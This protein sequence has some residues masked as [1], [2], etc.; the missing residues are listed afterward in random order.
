[1]SDQM[2]YDLSQATEG[3]PN[4]FIRK[5]YLSLL[6]NQNGSYS[7][8]QSV[9]DTSQLSNSNRYMGYQSAY[10]QIPMIMTLTADANSALFN[11]TSTTLSAD[12]A[13]GLKNW[14][15]SVIHSLQTD[16]NGVTVI[17][18][19]NF[20]G[21]WNTFKLMTTLSY[22]DILAHG[23][24]IGFYPDDA[25][26]VIFSAAANP[27]GVGTCFTQNAMTVPV[28]TGVHST[29]NSG[30]I[31]FFKRQQYINYDPVTSLAGILGGLTAPGSAAFSTL[32]TATNA[33]TAWK[34]HIFN[35]ILGDAGARG[36]IQWAINGIVKL[37]HLHNLF[38]K[39]PLLKGVYLKITLQLNNSVVN[40]S[41]AGAAGNLDVVSVSSAVGGVV[42][43]QIASAFT[44]NGGVATF[45]YVGNYTVSLA[46]GGSV[47]NSAQSA[48]AGVTAS[49]LGRNI[50][51]NVPSFVMSPAFEAAYLSSQVKTI[52]FSDI[53]Q[54]QVL[55]V[56]AG[57]NFNSLITNGIANIDKVLVL[58]FFTTAANGN[59]N[60]LYSPFDAAGTGVTS[61]CC[62]L[63]N[64]QVV[65]SGQNALYNTQ[66]Y[67][68]QQFVEQLS[69][70]NS[71]NGD[72]TDGLCSGLISLLDFE[73]AYN[74]YYVDVSRMLD[75]E[76]SV[77]KS[78]SIQGQNLSAKA[79][80]LIV[81]ISYKQTLRVDVL[82]GSR[83]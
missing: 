21:L 71:I 35:K 30:N 28:V 25:L 72:S 38:E 53:Y 31:G 41:S 9:I 33:A 24:E 18:Q 3:S 74:Y 62:L 58:P 6:D 77:P 10:L 82:T 14:Y 65:V 32:L 69:G 83:L 29:Y 8:N 50:T 76:R 56:T 70:C 5:D 37:R 68:Y 1:M 46:V 20:Q 63:T 15:G 16:Y 48:V 75:V 59:V 7:G 60:P 81:F 2:I 17:Q 26:A 57:A 36:V 39:M 34:S 79:I 40:F 55:N 11:P 52:E 80:D 44:N 42:P 78:V 22:D 66:K 61:P 67:S 45:G 47:L 27:N 13:C 54:Y 49:P 4:V 19:T 12:Y 51:L 43:I 23:S 73:T 64:F